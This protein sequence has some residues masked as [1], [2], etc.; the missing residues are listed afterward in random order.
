MKTS[1]NVRSVA[2]AAAVLV[3]MNAFASDKY[4]ESSSS[5]CPAPSAKARPAATRSSS[6]VKARAS[7][8]DSREIDGKRAFDREESNCPGVNALIPVLATAEAAYIGEYAFAQIVRG[9]Y[10]SKAT[11]VK[12]TVLAAPLLAAAGAG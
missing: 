4:E 10:T 2:I 8:D 1:N 6:P 3:S 5:Y 7:Y 11:A 9:A 12:N